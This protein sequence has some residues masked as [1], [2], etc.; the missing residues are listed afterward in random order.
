M[1]TI[2]TYILEK[3]K[4]TKS[5]NK[6][7]KL[8]EEYKLYKK[9]CN[10]LYLDDNDFDGLCIVAVNKRSKATTIFAQDDLSFNSY[11]ELME[12]IYGVCNMVTSKWFHLCPIKNNN[13]LNDYIIFSSKW[14]DTDM[15]FYRDYFEKLFFGEN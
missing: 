2:N 7:Y 12:D 3:L 9:M 5:S 10:D 13:P 1:K 11:R 14:I 6:E 8:H 4:I 15:E